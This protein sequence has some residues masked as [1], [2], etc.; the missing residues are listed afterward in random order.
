MTRTLLVAPTGHGVGLTAV[1]L[2]LVHAL[3]QQGVDVGFYKPLSQPRPDGAAVDRSTALV[4][5]TSS[6]HPPEPI[7]ADEVQSRLS[8]NALDQLM[9]DVVAAGEPVVSSH[10]VVVV[11]GLVPGSGLVYSGRANLALAKALDADVLLVG[12]MTGADIDSLAETM[13]IAARTYRAGEHD[14][15]VGA[16]AN[17]LPDV[18]APTVQ[19]LRTAPGR[20][21]HRAR[22]RGPVPAGA[23]LAA[24]ARHRRRPRRPGAQRGRAGPAGEGRHRRRAG[25]ARAAAAARGG[26]AASS[27]PA[28]GTR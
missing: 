12:A 7:A 6:L 11:E 8:Q 5:L 25:R 24:A 26:P 9:E 22:R 18:T 1:C 23:R 16:V 20:A 4:R 17:R 14:R 10:D 21:R 3:Q 27:C 2:G 19:Q 13:A 15:V 28:T